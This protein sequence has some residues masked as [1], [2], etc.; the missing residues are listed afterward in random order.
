MAN[1]EGS[2]ALTLLFF[3]SS[4]SISGV[5]SITLNLPAPHTT[6]HCLTAILVLY[7]KL[8]PLIESGG[9]VFSVN[10]EFAVGEKPLS[11]HDEVALIPPISGG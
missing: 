11:D 3:A 5:G 6:T 7:P 8:N 2:I 9:M 1:V 4:R 10:G